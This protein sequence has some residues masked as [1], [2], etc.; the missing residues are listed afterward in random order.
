MSRFV[1]NQWTQFRQRWQRSTQ[2][3]RRV[4][5]LVAVYL[6]VYL[7]I[8]AQ[9]VTHYYLLTP[10][11]NSNVA[12]ADAWLHGRLDLAE[13]TYDTALHD[14]KVYN[15]YPPMFTLIS[16]AIMASVPDGVPNTILI[17]LILL[18]LPGLA[19]AVFL[20]RAQRVWIAVLLSW[21][22]LL[23]TSLLPLLDRGLRNGEVWVVNHLLSQI[24][25]LIFLLDYF[26]RRRI[27]VGGVG[28]IVAFWSRQLTLLY[29]LPLA[30]AAWAAE[31]GASRRWRVAGLALVTAVM[32]ALPLTLNSL[33]FGNPLDSGY[34]YVYEGRWDDPDDWAA[35]SAARG[36]FSP[37]FAPRNLYYMN[38][39]L[40]LLDEPLWMLRPVPNSYG[41]GIWWTTPLLLF[42]LVYGRLLW[43]DRAV[44]ALVLAVGAIFVVLMTYHTTGW[45]QLGSNRFSLDFLVVLLA[46]VGP[47]CDGPRRRWVVLACVLWSVWYFRW[48]LG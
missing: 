47:H 7:L 10:R 37:V 11:N 42:A 40:P 26:G 20:R 25:L 16:A 48:A 32:A 1:E 18:P 38:I 45:A 15:V 14:G 34:R 39:G 30:A 8:D 41:T 12:E 9:P 33:K 5:G 13:R 3:Q 36:L 46:A 43:A 29:L 17:L 24:G 6:A 31:G 44:R 2:R 4:A 28:L 22:Y 23:G 19:Y 35:Q 27:W 21:G